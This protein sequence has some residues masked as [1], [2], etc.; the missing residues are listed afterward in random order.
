MPLAF[1]GVC[2][3]N[4]LLLL[5]CSFGKISEH[6][7]R[8]FACRF[9]GKEK[10]AGI[11]FFKIVFYVLYSVQSFRFIRSMGLYGYQIVCNI[12]T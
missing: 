2:P 7:F 4:Y 5:L 6:F 9:R 11:R 1:Y 10:G 3:F 8:R 12:S